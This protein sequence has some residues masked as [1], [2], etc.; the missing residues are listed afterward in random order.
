ME[1]QPQSQQQQ[2]Q[3]ER[4]FDSIVNE[5]KQIHNIRFELH[6]YQNQ[7]FRKFFRDVPF[8]AV[9]VPTSYGKSLIP[10]LLPTLNN[11]RRQRPSGKYK[12]IIHYTHLPFPSCQFYA[13]TYANSVL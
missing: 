10:I 9:S 12:I 6:D 8:I 11:L 1:E 2:L 4:C 5:A 3:P 13:H 7:T